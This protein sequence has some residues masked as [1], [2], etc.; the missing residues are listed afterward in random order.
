MLMNEE[1]IFSLEVRLIQGIQQQCRLQ[2]SCHDRQVC[3]LLLSSIHSEAKK[4]ER[5]KNDDETKDKF[6]KK[7]GVAI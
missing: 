1:A 6:I 7:T 2:P 5:I 4:M 3:N